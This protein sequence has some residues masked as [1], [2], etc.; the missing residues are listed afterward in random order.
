MSAEN[1]PNA[2]TKPKQPSW[3]ELTDEQRWDR[4]YAARKKKAAQTIKSVPFA[5]HLAL[6]PYLMLDAANTLSATGVAY[7]R[8]D[9]HKA[10]ATSLALVSSRLIQPER[11]KLAIKLEKFGGVIRRTG[12]FIDGKEYLYAVACAT[13]KLA[14]EWRYPPDAPATLAALVLKEDAEWEDDRDNDWGLSKWHAIEATTKVYETM[15][16]TGMFPE[17]E[18][19]G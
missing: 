3:R 14:D 17:I 7:L 10:V 11:K 15:T 1:L 5:V 4:I 8:Q 19:W 9:A 12:F 2:T 16:D 13:V 6:P 18:T